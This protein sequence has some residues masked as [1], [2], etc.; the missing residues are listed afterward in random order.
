M[1]K[2]EKRMKAKFAGKCR[3]CGEPIHE[4]D[5]IYWSQAGGARHAPDCG[6]DDYRGETAH[7]EAAEDRRD[8]MAIRQ[9]NIGD[10]VQQPT[11]PDEPECMNG[12]DGCQGA[13]EYRAPLSGTGK[14]FARCDAHWEAR[15][16]AQQGINER[17]PQQQPADFDPSYAGESWDET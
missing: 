8:V 12:P 4:D 14:S 9:F 11:E 13:T 10:R 1:S 2:A 3:E 15:L 17:Y 16:E 7:I 5:D 6:Y